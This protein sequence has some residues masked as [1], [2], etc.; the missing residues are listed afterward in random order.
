MNLNITSGLVHPQCRSW[1][2]FTIMWM[3]VYISNPEV[4]LNPFKSMSNHVHVLYAYVFV[5]VSV[6]VCVCVCMF[7][8]V[9]MCV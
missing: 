6:V 8:S 7:L 3:Y 1:Y 2:Q 9:C 5:C 4:L